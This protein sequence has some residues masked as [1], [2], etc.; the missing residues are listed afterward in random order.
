MSNLIA[1]ATLGLN[2]QALAILAMLSRSPC[3]D[4]GAEYEE[5]FHEFKIEIKTFAWYNG[6]ERG[7]LLEVRPSLSSKRAL[8]ITFGEHRNSDSIFIDAWEVNEFFLNPPTVA[9][10]TDEAY[11]ARTWVDYGNVAKAI[12]VIRDKISAFMAEANKPVPARVLP[13]LGEGEETP[14]PPKPPAKVKRGVT[15][16]GKCP[17]RAIMS[18]NSNGGWENSS[19]GSLQAEVEASYKALCD[20]FGSPQFLDETGDGDGKVSTEWIIKSD[21]GEILTIYD[22]KETSLYDSDLPSPAEFRKRAS[23]E[24]HIGGKDKS[25]ADRFVTWLRNELQAREI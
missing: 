20:L 3:D 13:E 1:D 8:L 17:Y 14:N 15:R 7:V 11:K 10:F 12:E 4:L 16:T 21:H 24:W 25:S 6:R 5:K 19:G 23:Y 2:A 22:Y 18:R 9:D